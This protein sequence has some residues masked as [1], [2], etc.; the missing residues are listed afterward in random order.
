MTAVTMVT[1]TMVPAIAKLVTPV[2]I[3]PSARAPENAPT[4]AFARTSPASVT[5]SFP[6]MIVPYEAARTIAA[7]TDIARMLRASVNLDSLERTAR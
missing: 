3:V 5:K 4:T 7:T 1:A 2:L 6:D